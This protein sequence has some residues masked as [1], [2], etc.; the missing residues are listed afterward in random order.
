MATGHGKGSRRG[1]ALLALGLAWTASFQA[2]AATSSP[3]DSLPMVPLDTVLA[4]V[5]RR[6]PELRMWDLRAQGK[7]ASAQGAGAWMAPE[8]GIGGS[9]LAYGGASGMAPGDPA[10][11]ISARQMIPGPGKRAFRR[12][13]LASLAGQERAEGIRTRA[14]LM[15]DAKTQYYRLAMA[16][17]ARKRAVLRESEG[18]MVFMLEVAEVRFKLRRGD[19][20]TVFEA[21]ARLEEL[22][23][24]QSMEEGMGHQAF[25]ALSH[26]MA[27]PEAARFAADTGVR[28]RGLA[29]APDGLALDRRGDLIRIDK[30]LE[31]MELQLEAMRREARPDFGIQVDHME[32]F[33]MGRRFSAMA[34]MTLPS[35]P[36]SSGMVRSDVKAMR[37]DIESMRADREA[38]RL[39]ARRMAEEMRLML[40]NESELYAR[41]EEDVAPAYRKSL[42]AAMAVYQ[43]GAG[44]LFR[45]LDTWDRWVM[46]RMESLGH[47]E[48]ALVLEAEY[49]RESGRL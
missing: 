2:L 22:R 20:A 1:R 34:M 11:M 35:A 46:A 26:L 28:L 17:S 5:L 12:K 3:S 33:Q 16:M 48:K 39:M 14:R 44:D 36:W 4:R 6:N 24:M 9:D 8:L 25:S 49:E 15:A 40:R 45:V 29:Q 30:E 47:L 31:S 18:V 19:M 32:M 10:L 38:M 42:D 43:E 21:R 23:S 13:H 7:A 27:M 37:K 41:F